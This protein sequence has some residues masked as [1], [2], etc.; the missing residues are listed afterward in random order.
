[1]NGKFVLKTGKF[2]KQNRNRKKQ[3][4]KKVKNNGV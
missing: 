3:C 1:M 2:E 4:K